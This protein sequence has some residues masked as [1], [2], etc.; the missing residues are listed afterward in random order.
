M[1][2]TQRDS[3]QKHVSMATSETPA[4]LIHRCIT[5]PWPHVWNLFLETKQKPILTVTESCFY[6]IGK[7][8]I[9]VHL[10]RF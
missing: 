4:L 9:F 3:Q 8:G 2:G 7:I 10:I 1:K 6:A 5:V